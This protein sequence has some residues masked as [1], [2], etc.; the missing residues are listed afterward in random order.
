MR[1]VMLYCTL[2]C[3]VLT[4]CAPVKPDSAQNDQ[5]QA[6]VHYKLAMAHLQS[7]NP[8]LA[9]KELL[10]AVRQ[11]PDN[12]AIHV[13]LAQ[14]YQQ[15]KAYHQAEKHYLE[16]LRLSDNDP[17]YQNNLGSLYLDM[18]QWDQAISYFDQAAANLLFMNAHVA[19]TGKAYALYRKGNYDAALDT[20]REAV[21][22]APRYAPAYYYR[23]R[24]YRDLG[25]FAKERRSLREALGYAP[26]FLAAR[27]RLAE[28][29]AGRKKYGQARQELKTILEF[30]PSSEWGR[31][32]EALL[33]TLP[34]TD[35]PADRAVPLAPA[36]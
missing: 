20:F 29:Y 11:D 22:L 18:K 5:Q 23:S 35:A 32:A 14:A 1:S 33:D 30:A 19:V 25:D 4:A 15:K 16:A 12:D 21:T 27:Y 7:D 10:V 17:R 28:L 36:E 6:Q 8:T 9:L 26:Q 34:A 24:V 13:A 31:R 3:L 2:W